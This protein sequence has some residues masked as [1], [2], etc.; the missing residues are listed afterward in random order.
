MN[1]I[2]VALVTGG[3]R[4]IGRGICLALAREGFTV[5]INYN[6]NLAA[7]EETRDL[8]EKEGGSAELCQADVSLKEH[9]D[10]LLDFCMETLG[11]LD[12][13]V[14]NAGIAPPHRG[15]LRQG[16]QH[17]PQVGLLHESGGSPADDRT[18]R[19]WAHFFGGD[20]QCVLHECLHGQHQPGGILRE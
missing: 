12:V 17:Q 16:G 3:S 8:I 4:G 20:H 1:G 19:A 15:E 9:R 5:L 14:N 2:P 13:L 6:S 10:L 11:R 18:D 7:A